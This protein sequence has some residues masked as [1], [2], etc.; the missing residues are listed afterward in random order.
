MLVVPVVNYKQMQ[1]LMD[2]NFEVVHDQLH[3]L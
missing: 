2:I 1:G 3:R